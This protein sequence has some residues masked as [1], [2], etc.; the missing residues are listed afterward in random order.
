MTLAERLQEA[1]DKL[2]ALNKTTFWNVLD[3]HHVFFLDEADVTPEDIIGYMGLA[4]AI[5]VVEALEAAFILM[6]TYA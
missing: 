6:E 2:Y 3:G 4:E 1:A 5:R